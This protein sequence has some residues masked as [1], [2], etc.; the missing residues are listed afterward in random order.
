MDFEMS[1]FKTTSRGP[2][3]KTKNLYGEMGVHF[4]GTIGRRLQKSAKR[5]FGGYFQLAD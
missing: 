5:S 1:H 3:A 4:N 2:F